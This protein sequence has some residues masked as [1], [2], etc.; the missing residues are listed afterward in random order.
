VQRDVSLHP[1]DDGRWSASFGPILLGTLD[2]ARPE[3]G[4]IRPPPTKR[5]GPVSTFSLDNGVR[6]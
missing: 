1:A 3:R 2:E 5:T 4:L 6:R